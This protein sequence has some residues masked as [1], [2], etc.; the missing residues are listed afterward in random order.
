MIIGAVLVTCNL[1]I[2]AVG[3][4]GLILLC[5]RI[6]ME[7]RAMTETF[8]VR[9]ATYKKRTDRLIPGFY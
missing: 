2:G 6:P 1:F 8:G 7:E 9:Y 4:I 3:I 5:F